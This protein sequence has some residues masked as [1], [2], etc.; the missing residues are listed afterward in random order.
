[1]DLK[2][3][4]QEIRDI[5]EKRRNDL[6][7]IFEE[8]LHK[9]TM[10]NTEGVIKS[11]WPSVSKV[12]KSFYQEFPT[13]EAAEKK[14]KGDPVLKEKLIKEWAEAGTYSTN[15]GSRTH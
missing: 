12:L 2:I 7:L 8:E 15:M 11:D 13:D 14:S 1:M 4:S 10:K 6:N 3:I 9:Y 5:L